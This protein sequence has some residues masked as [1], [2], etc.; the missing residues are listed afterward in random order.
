MKGK[1]R[2]FPRERIRIVLH[3]G[4]KDPLWNIGPHGTF[5]LKGGVHHPECNATNTIKIYTLDRKIKIL[6]NA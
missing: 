2:S 3:D 5:D 1:I 6:N 4:V